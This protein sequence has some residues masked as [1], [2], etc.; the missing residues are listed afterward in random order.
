M[1]RLY[2]TL[3]A[4]AALLMVAPLA[5][6]APP[7]WDEQINKPTRFKVLTDFGGA[8]VLDRETGLVWEQSQDFI[9]RKWGAAQIHCNQRIV[10]NRLGW[11]L[12]TIQELVSLVD[13]TVPFPGPGLPAGHPFVKPGGAA[14]G[15]LLPAPA[16]PTP[17]GCSISSFPKAPPTRSITRTPASSVPPGVFAA[18]RVW[19]LSDLVI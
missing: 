1:K 17:R 7:S 11:R 6:A 2:G 18:D 10:G 16:S 4:I 19:T 13:P 14:T 9:V 3:I 15:R 8:A 5:V 12:P